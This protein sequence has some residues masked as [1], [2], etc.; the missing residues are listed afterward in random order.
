MVFKDKLNNVLLSNIGAVIQTGT[1]ELLAYPERKSVYEND[2]AEEN[3]SQYDLDNPKFKDKEVTLKMA[4]LADD[5]TQYWQYSNALFNELKKAGQLAL[6]IFD[7]DKTYQVFYMKS[8][9]FKKTFKRLKN[10]EKVFV[11]FDLT[12]KVLY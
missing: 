10:T 11:K 2:W 3:G 8:G 5:N 1:E 6:Y 4:I 7:H 9:N 12:F